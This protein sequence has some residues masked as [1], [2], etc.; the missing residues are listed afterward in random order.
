MKNQKLSTRQLQ[1]HIID[2]NSLK[3]HESVLKHQ[4]TYNAPENHGSEEIKIE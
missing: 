4:A 1:I 2:P 3:T